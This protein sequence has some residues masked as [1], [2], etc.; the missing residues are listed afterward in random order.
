MYW[1]ETG[2]N[3][4][5]FKAAI[6]STPSSTVPTYT[7]LKSKL[8]K[9]IFSVSFENEIFWPNIINFAADSIYIDNGSPNRRQLIKCD[10][11]GMWLKI[12][13]KCVLKVKMS[14]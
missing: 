9:E 1:T 2:V 6:L 7:F 10:S 3:P 4:N 13:F 14:N 8:Q 12:K 5:I 11:K